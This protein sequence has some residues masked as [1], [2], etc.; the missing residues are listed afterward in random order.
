MTTL[1]ARPNYIDFAKI[2]GIYCVLVGHYVYFM[3][4]P[5]KLSD[6]IPLKSNRIVLELS[7]GII[8]TLA[9]H[10][11][12]LF[13]LSKVFCSD[14]FFAIIFCSVFVLLITWLLIIVCKKKFPSL[15]GYR[16]A[17]IKK[18]ME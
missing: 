13:C 1:P 11:I 4:V 7:D 12:I 6:F 2:I 16:N 18:I 15:L 17:K 10:K 14:N 9:S 8:S 3:E 5:F